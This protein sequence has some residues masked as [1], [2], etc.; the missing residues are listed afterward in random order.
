MKAGDVFEKQLA[1]LVED[2]VKT[3]MHEIRQPLSAMLA[4]A[5]AARSL[6]GATADVRGYL[7]RIIDQVQE[8][9][10][11][12]WSVLSAGTSWSGSDNSRVDL[13]EIVD[14]VVGAIRL[15]SGGTVTRRGDR[16]GWL[17][18]HGSRAALRRCLIDV[19]DNAAR[20][21]GPGG[22]VTVSLRRGA[23]A[24]RILV[25][26]DGP[27]FGRLPSGTGLGLA[28]TRQTL[29]GMG[30]DLSVGLP[31]GTGGARVAITLPVAVADPADSEN[32]VR[33]G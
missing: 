24:V 21:A 32:S 3:V 8:V 1:P 2:R 6:P 17:T 27:G 14:S 13:D 9:S 12:A 4:L 16:G 20:A 22:T 15:T 26:D 33:A 31:T 28:I 19:V 25:E 23:D 10:G 18:L 30:G 7:D 11:A 5:E 29:E